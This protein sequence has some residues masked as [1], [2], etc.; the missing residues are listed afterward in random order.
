MLGVKITL[1]KVQIYARKQG[2]YNWLKLLHFKR[3][4]FSLHL[5]E[6]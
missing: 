3:Q 2:I 6:P 4:T 1:G 5:G